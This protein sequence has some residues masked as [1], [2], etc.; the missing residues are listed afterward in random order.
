MVT[1]NVTF[2]LTLAIVSGWICRQVHSSNFTPLLLLPLSQASPGR[3][4]LNPLL[5]LPLTQTSLISLPC[6]PRPLPGGSP[7]DHLR[8]GGRVCTTGGLG[9]GVPLPRGPL[10]VRGGIRRGGAGSLG[11]V[12]PTRQT[13]LDYPLP[14][15]YGLTPCVPFPPLS[16]QLCTG[17]P[18]IIRRSYCDADRPVLTVGADRCLAWASL[19]YLD[20]FHTPRASNIMQCNYYLQQLPMRQSM[21]HSLGFSGSPVAATSA[22]IVT[23]SPGSSS[24][25]SC[26]Q[27]Q[28]L[29]GGGGGPKRSSFK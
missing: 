8:C 6:S 5:L 29:G 3:I 9:A 11:V 16:L 13:S 1:C 7:G 4:S 26:G 20:L 15:P 12:R 23:A 24:K 22:G 18:Q 10:E 21:D 25:M 17:S 14:F 2:R 27:Q 28:Q 19:R